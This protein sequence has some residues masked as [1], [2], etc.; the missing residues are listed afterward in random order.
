MT[1][2]KEIIQS[3]GFFKSKISQ[4]LI[5]TLVIIFLATA[6]SARKQFI[7]DPYVNF[8]DMPQ[9]YISTHSENMFGE[10]HPLYSQENYVPPGQKIVPA[11]LLLSAWFHIL[12]TVVYW[13]M[14][15]GGVFA[16]IRL[17]GLTKYQSMVMTLFT[18][19]IGNLITREIF[20]IPLLAPAPFIGY[21]YYTF[22]FP[23]IPISIVGL[24]LM[25]KKRFLISG[26][27][28][29]LTT[30]FHM[31]FGFR[32]FG[33]LFFSLLLWKVWGSQRLDL[34]K[35]D[36]SWRNIFTFAM[37]WGILFITTLWDIQSSMHFFDSLDFPQGQPLKSQL[38]WLIQNEPDDWLISYHFP[39]GRPLFGFFF[40][41]IAIG[42]FCEIILKFTSVSTLRKF[43]VVWEIATLGAVLFFGFG[44]LFES[45]LIDFLPLSLAHAIT[46][47]RFWDLIWVVVM[48]FWTTL[49]LAVA[50]VGQK[51]FE[52]NE[53]Y[54][55][56]AGNLIFHF[57]MTLFVSINIVI[58]FSGKISILKIRDYEG[59]QGEF[60]KVSGLRSGKIPIIKIR[61]YVQICDDVTPEY[62][63]LYWVAVR[64]IQEKDDMGFQGALSRLNEIYDEF[65]ENLENPPLQN[66][67]SLLL[68]RLNYFINSRYAM[69]IK[70]SQKL[71][72]ASGND[73]YWWSCLHSEPGVHRR[74]IEVPTKDYLDA[75]EWIKA[76]IPLD[77]GIIQP[78]YLSKFY[79]LTDHVGFWDG[80][81]DQHMM[82]IIK[83][84]YGIGLHRLRSVAGPYGYEI[85]PGNKNKGL[86]PEGIWF[87]LDLTK[88]Q[89]FNIHRDYPE[90]NYLL[91][92]NKSLQGYPAVYSNPSLALYDISKP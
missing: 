68:N 32:F 17:G 61:D 15:I 3:S 64:A 75:A 48:G 14:V 70:E 51:I 63:K 65:K 28:I 92:E 83:G 88:E 9:V 30:F 55:F 84:Y 90:Y 79:M 72:N 1:D 23:I 36:I 46:L 26:V 85:E 56:L 18:M 71:K 16:L 4:N 19:F 77:T 54:E 12:S 62:K 45:F 74:S 24:F 60:V 29:G 25:L 8:I 76:N 38:A 59:K 13:A 5:L 87:F 73:V 22:S 81:I 35:N 47:T 21:Q 2:K 6:I 10:I 69:S 86:G 27:M 41:A 89:I 34:S 67:D 33:L 78:P 58:F 49:F 50:V 37:G 57:F 11:S 52:K 53:K 66:M 91:T 44:F 31:K 20:G 43:A 40:M 82:Y 7:I 42:T 39:L 80:K